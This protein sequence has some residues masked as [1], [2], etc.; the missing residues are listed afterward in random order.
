MA[1]EE[2]AR[3]IERGG[4]WVADDE[5]EVVGAALCWFHDGDCHLRELNV[6]PS[7]SRKG[8]GR[9]LVETV[10]AEAARRGCARV[11]LTTFVEVPFNGPWY[12][13]MGFEVIEEPAGWV[14]DERA[15]EAREGLDRQ[16]RQAM[17]RRLR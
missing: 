6:L 11:V 13:R 4:V 2:V 16:P 10:V 12:A 9:Q 5:G 15:D 7:H 14:A 1:A 17:A 3:A 8:L